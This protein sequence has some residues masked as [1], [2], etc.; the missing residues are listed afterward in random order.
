MMR[1]LIWLDE[2]GFSGWGCSEC[3]W[4]FQNPAVIGVDLPPMTEQQAG[5]I[6]HQKALDTFNAHDCLSY[7]RRPPASRRD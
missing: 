7:P 2:V 5:E 6:Y 1:E 4:I 3:G